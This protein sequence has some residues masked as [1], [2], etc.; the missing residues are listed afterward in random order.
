MLSLLK[1]VHKL[2]EF[3]RFWGSGSSVLGAAT[4]TSLSFTA[5]Y[6][7]TSP[8]RLTTHLS[9]AWLCM[10]VSP[11]NLYRLNSSCTGEYKRDGSVNE[12]KARIWKPPERMPSGES[13]RGGDVQRLR[14][15]DRAEGSD[16]R[17]PLCSL[18]AESFS[19]TCTAAWRSVRQRR[20][21]LQEPG[22]QGCHRSRYLVR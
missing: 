4:F 20:V 5:S 8:V 7:R 14:M 15:L 1:D 2:W 13:W 11:A 16:P 3:R 10:Q 9:S 12:R 21:C 19:M 18:P 17:F 22:I 6:T